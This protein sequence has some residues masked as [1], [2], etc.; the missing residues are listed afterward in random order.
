MDFND[1]TGPMGA[2]HSVVLFIIVCLLFTVVI[3]LQMY[4]AQPYVRIV[5]FKYKSNYY[6]TFTIPE[7]YDV[8][9]QGRKWS[10]WHQDEKG[11]AKMCNLFNHSAGFLN[12]NLNTRASKLGMKLWGEWI[13]AYLSELEKTDV[14]DPHFQGFPWGKNWYEFTISS[15]TNMAYY[16]VNKGNSRAVNVA[17]A[18]AIQ[19]IIIDPEHSLGYTRDKA[20]SA[21]MV[22]P[23]TLSHLITGTL[24]KTNPSYKYAIQQYDLAPNPNIKLNEDGVHIDYAYLIHNGVYAY[25]YFESIYA[26]YPDTKQI[27][28]EVA[29][30]NIDYHHDMW[31]AKLYHP[32]IGMSGSTLFHRQNN[33]HCNTY[34]GKQKLGSVVT[35]PSMRYLRIFGENFQWSVRLG[36]MSIVYYECDQTVYNMG[37]YSCLCKERFVKGSSTEATF[38]RSGFIWR[39][40]SP[41]LTEVDPNPD[42]VEHP[43]T[44][45]YK[46]GRSSEEAHS[47]VFVDYDEGVAFFEVMHVTYQPLLDTHIGESGYFDFQTGVLKYWQDMQGME[48]HTSQHS[49]QWGKDTIDLDHDPLLDEKKYVIEYLMDMRTG[50]TSYQKSEVADKYFAHIH[51][52]NSIYNSFAWPDTGH[53]SFPSAPSGK[54]EDSFSIIWKHNKPFIYMPGENEIHSYEKTVTYR[55]DTM[56]FVFD[57]EWNQ[58]LIK[59]YV[60]TNKY[61]LWSIDD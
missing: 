12:D 35:V 30:K 25:G 53:G 36:G 38:P 2:F 20:N 42:N 27:I 39:T 21:M 51:T 16:I 48:N 59:D 26:I 31:T 54:A 44:Y 46:S 17:A 56:H 57:Q 8:D 47:F 43:T 23:W 3:Y 58:Y 11:I 6:E 60:K 15:T 24:D 14:T 10:N 18:K 40:D 32:T 22:F 7:G 29:E 13:V 49:T 55:G 41:K 28:S 5:N 34:R 33:T 19:Y 61:L 45:G 9:T 50:E 4:T 37:L 52:L 1:H